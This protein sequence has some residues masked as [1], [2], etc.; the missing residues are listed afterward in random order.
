MSIGPNTRQLLEEDLLRCPACV[1][2]PERRQTE[3]DPGRL[4]LVREAW[5]VCQSPGCGRKYPV[6]D[7]IPVLLISEGDRYRHVAVEDL[8]SP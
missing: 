3:E 1:T 6:R 8:G 4:A 2:D 7:D 5:L